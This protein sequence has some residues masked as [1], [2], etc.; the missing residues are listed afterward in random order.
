MNLLFLLNIFLSIE[1][2]NYLKSS[3]ANSFNARR[4]VSHS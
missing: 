3:G 4:Q 2:F 1:C